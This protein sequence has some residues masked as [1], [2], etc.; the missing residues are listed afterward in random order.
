MPDA[1]RLVLLDEVSVGIEPTAV[2]YSTCCAAPTST[3]C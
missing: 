2:S 1:S 3:Q